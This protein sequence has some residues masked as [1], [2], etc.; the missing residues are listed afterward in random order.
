MQRRRF[1]QCVTGLAALAARGRASAQTAREFDFI[2][3]GAGSSGCVLANRLSANPSTSVL[4]IEAGGPG[5]GEPAIATPGR[6]VS[7]LGSAWDWNYAI[8]PDPGLG[9]RSIRWPR[10]KAYGGSS[11]INAMAY[12]RG[13][14]RCYEAWARAAGPSWRY[15]A[16][17]PLFTRV[18]QSLAISETGDPHA[19]HLAFMEA[20]RER[21]YAPQF[22]RKTIRNGQ[23]HSAAD[24]F[25]TPA[26]SRRN[27]TVLPNAIVRRVLFSR[28]RATAVEVIRDG[29]A[30]QIRA[31][32]EIVLAAGVI[33]S[34]RTLMLSGVGPADA[35]QRAGI[36]VVV[37]SRA[38]GANLHDHPRVSV[39][40]KSA[41]RLA[42]S[43]TSAG[44]WVASTVTSSAPIPNV[45]DLQ[46]YVGRGLDAP[47]DFITLTVALAQP[48]SRGSVE[49]PS[50]DPTAAPIIRANYFAEPEDLLALADGVRIA[51]EIAA[52][53][54][55]RGL[56]GD[57]LDPAATV[58]TIDAVR[59][60]IRRAADTIF[61]P[62]GT[63]RMGTAGDAVVD[64]E[65]RVRG[66][67][68]L[69]IADGSVMPIVVNSQTQAA[70]FVIAERAAERMIASEGA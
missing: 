57:A 51:R 58:I 45:P 70:C 20:A 5:A 28:Q 14:A 56:R 69:R 19:G 65:L 12:V 67:E 13:D 39:R 31:A 22:Y 4:L 35:L 52:A 16:L 47:D 68:G 15:G 33:G 32:Q 26:L 44:L 24:A 8:E 62:V 23:R 7:L 49:L 48:R 11:A 34:P 30:Q 27:L 43:T 25:L 9:G 36:P 55:Y 21:G 10:G 17:E 46:F 63:C 29:E 3:V 54:A 61:H 18:E 40:W 59:E 53:P 64:S 41:Q 60:W 50:A 1:L 38:V 6:W 2:I 66:V 42:P 37:D